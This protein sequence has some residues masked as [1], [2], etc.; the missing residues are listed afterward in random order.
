[1]L[2]GRNS[3]TGTRCGQYQ[4]LCRSLCCTFA[5]RAKGLK[6]LMRKNCLEELQVA[7]RFVG[8]SSG[9]PQ[10]KAWGLVFRV[11]E[12]FIHHLRYACEAEAEAR[13]SA[14]MRH[15]D[16]QKNSNNNTQLQMSSSLYHRHHHNQHRHHQH[17][18]LHHEHQHCHNHNHLILILLLCRHHHHNHQPLNPTAPNRPGIVITSSS[19]AL[20]TQNPEP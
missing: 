13:R 9:A 6:G 17:Q 15:C 3:V 10:S 8:L 19:S 16:Q 12:Q 4:K 1:M 14:A 2:L 11:P 18:H 5:G 20:S 7:G